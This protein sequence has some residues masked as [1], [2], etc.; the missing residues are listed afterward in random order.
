MNRIVL[1]AAAMVLAA[2]ASPRAE[3]R[4][5]YPFKSAVITYR[6]SGS[7]QEGTQVVTID[8]HG[9]RART[10][11]DTTLFLMGRKHKESIVEIDDG[12]S[13]YRIDLVKKTGEKSPSP[14][15]IA[16][17]MVRSMSPAQKKELEKVGRELAKGHTASGELKR[18]GKGK[19][20]GRECD[21]YEAMGMK[22]W[23]WNNLS[24]RK[25]SPSLGSMVQEAVEIRVDEPIPPDRFTPPR[26][27]T[28]TDAS[29]DG[30]GAESALAP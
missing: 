21:I 17:E 25:E 20:L 2:P 29:R 22:T 10:D 26:G 19:V 1:F 11:R 13:F 12:E 5:R 4:P 14:S 6:I 24:L 9:R 27:V 3:E 7:I 8:D 15:R 16:A 28:I 18:A 23:L 30:E